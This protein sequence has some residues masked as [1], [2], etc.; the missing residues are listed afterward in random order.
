MIVHYLKI[1]WRNL[2]KYKTQTI[3]SMLGLTIGVVFF[4]YGYHW[5]KYETTYD[6]FYPNSE[7]I[8][9]VY[10]VHKSSNKPYEQGCLPYVA[11]EKL[12]NAF[13]EIEEVAIL[14][15][16]YGSALKYN[17]EDL[18]YPELLFVDENFF[19]MFPPRVILGTVDDN[20][21]KNADEIV[22]TESFA[23]KHFNVPD[24]A[25]GKTLVSGYNESY[26]IKAV[27]ENPPG[28]TIFRD[29]GYVLDHF[30]RK[31]SKKT[32]EVIQWRDF[33][34][35]RP[36][37]LL[38]NKTDIEKFRKKL[39]T[40]AID[41]GYNDDLLFEMTPLSSVKRVISNPFDKEA[42][43]LRYIRTFMFAGIL[44]LFAAFFNY[45]NILINTTLTRV[46]EMNLRRVTGASAIDIFRQL[47]V[48]MTLLII[49]VAFLSFCT[50]E[51]TMKIFENTFA[52]VVITGKVYTVLLS[53][54]GIVALLLYV[55][56]YFF[57]YRFIRKTSY[58]QHFSRK[59]ALFYGRIS[60]VLQLI[61]SVFFMTS[62]FVFYRQ[63]DFMK[64]ADWG[65]NK[66]NL[67]QIEMNLRDREGLMRAVSQ[68]PMV[69]SI[70][71]SDYFTILQ[72]TDQMGA[73]GVTGIEW[74][75]KPEGYNPAFQVIGVGENFIDNFELTIL[76]GRDFVAE[77]F[78]L[79]NGEQT[80]KI[81]LNETAKKVLEIENPI[82]KKIIIPTNW[83]SH[84][85]RG[86]EEFEIIGIIKDFHTV[87]L[88]DTQP[89]LLIKGARLKS[90]GTENYVRVTQGME[91]EAIE[92]INKIIPV[93][94]PD[95]D[96]EILV[97]SMNFLLNELSKTEQDLLKLFFTVSLFCILIAVF[98]IYSVSQREMQRRQKE[99]AI[100]KTAGAYTREIMAMFFREYILITLVACAV[101]LPLAGFFMQRWLETFAYRISISWWMFAVVIAVVVA[102]VSITILSRVIRAAGQNPAEVV[103]SE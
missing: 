82:G 22:V 77:D 92:A 13:P 76:G 63:V 102:I 49:V 71:E 88:Q 101:A 100:R 21:L 19:H 45:L 59:T 78:V 44:L 55:I 60:L 17:D 67:L 98:G 35:A 10:G 72:N 16:N 56:T 53:T 83:F 20:T 48:E 90:V 30:A 27:I 93:Y 79:R 39:R 95:K 46:R 2:H 37:F 8:Y 61:I 7:R 4:A 75:G 42:F 51:I 73:V 29:E 85:G 87:G 12:K 14:F 41:N 103:K 1:A 65:F 89:P 74:E 38:H 28:N 32:E 18:G 23:R 70:I 15:P 96:G 69:E 47:F 24:S 86:K 43:D 3:I 97:K 62:A 9:R 64:H 36:F 26:I 40:F 54:I 25:L 66:E 52:T 57:L 11:V 6:S 33:T 99:I 81:V 58:R 68:L 50:V 91:Q 84:D 34:D 80:N 31:F 94:Q 5:Y